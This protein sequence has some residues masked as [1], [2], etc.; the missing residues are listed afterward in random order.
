MGA[1]A[2]AGGTALMATGVGA[3]LGAALDVAGTGLAISGAATTIGAVAA[4]NIAYAVQNG[5]GGG[6][7]GTPHEESSDGKDAGAA[8]LRFEHK[9][10]D[11]KPQL[12]EE[13][14]YKALEGGPD[15][16]TAEVNP[17]A[18]GKN[19]QGQKNPDVKLLDR[20]G[21]LAG[22]REVK[23]I[24]NLKQARFM[25]HLSSAT[26]Q[27]KAKGAKINEIFFQVPKGSDAY[28][29]LGTGR[30][31]RAG[32]SPSGAGTP[33]ASWTTPAR[34]SAPMTWGIPASMTW[35]RAAEAAPGSRTRRAPGC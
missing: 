21:N 23:T 12:T 34:N 4:P 35:A 33:S 7:G 16:A 1:G 30:S 32:T 18:K 9:G 5:D 3:P 6:G 22:Y 20:Q 17:E 24:A 11:G 25:E 27:L 26:K 13:N 31:S 19:E 14:A 28:K 8:S 10:P 2:D 15:D 29:W